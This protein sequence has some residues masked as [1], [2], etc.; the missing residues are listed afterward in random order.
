[1]KRI[2]LAILLSLSFI[3]YVLSQTEVKL[4]QDPA[5][6]PVLDKVSATLSSDRAYN[7]E[8]RYEIES[9]A[10]QYKVEDF[11]SIIIKGQK[12]KLKTDDGEVFYN[13]K[14]MWTY[15]HV[16]EEVYVSTPDTG[17][18]DQMFTAPF[19]LLNNYK[20]YFKYRLRED[21]RSGNRILYEVDLY[22]LSLETSF[23]IIKVR[24]DKTSGRLHSFIV[25]QKNGISV[26]ILIT[27]IIT[28]INISDSAFN[29]NKEQYPD[30][31]MIEL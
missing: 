6:E 29:W 18:L 20:Q 7:I 13:G 17:N 5:A 23:S 25:Q 15:S 1:M 4:L 10:E 2:N 21:V 14:R 11:G 24:V 27:E 12:Y 16:N 31:L 8:F 9:A 30:V 19:I 3:S 26:R 22:P 28:N